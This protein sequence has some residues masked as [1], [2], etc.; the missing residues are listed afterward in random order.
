MS[1]GPLAFLSPWLLTGLLALPIIYWLLRTVPPRPKQVIFPPTRI[2]AGLENEEKQP[3]KTPWWLMLIR[4]LAAGLVILALADP[5]LNPNRAGGV[6]GKGPMVLVVDNTWAAAS[7]WSNR[8]TMLDR[9][10]AEAQSTSR[11]VVVAPTALTSRTPVAR[12]EAPNDAA[13]TAAAIQPQPYAPDRLAALGAVEK[14][15]AGRT[16]I[17]L[18]WLTDGLMHEADVQPVLDRMAKLA[19]AGVTVVEAGRGEEPLAVAADLGKAGRLEAIVTRPGGV[20]R[21]GFLH[22]YSQRGQR[23]GEA[24]FDF[25]AGATSTRTAFELPLEL[26]NQVFRIAVSANPSAGSVHLIDARS[27][28]QRIAII[29]GA[30]QEQAQPLLGPLYYIARAIR[31]FAEVVEPN[32][33]NIVENIDTALNQ[34]STVIIMADV[35]TLTDDVAERLGKWVEKGGV[36]VRFAGPRLEKG[37]DNLLPVPLRL[38]GRALGGALSWSTPQP[39]APLP[40]D[41]PFAGLPVTPDVTINR[42]V[43]AD[44]ARMGTD[45]KVWARLTDGTP[46]VTAAARENGQLVLFHITANAEWSNLPLSGLFVE[47]LRRLSTLGRLG[48]SGE[49][50]E[51]AADGAPAMAS[52]NE[53]NV[54]TPVQVLD[55]FGTLRTP[56]P[57]A[58]PIAASAF[59]KT[60]PG[61]DH[62][63]GYY[64]PKSAPRALNVANQKTI[65]KPL[66]ALPAGAERRAYQ[67]QVS[68]PLKP[69]LF[70]V[71]LALLFTDIVAVLLLQAGSLGAL[72]TRRAA[73]R[74]ATLAAVLAVPLLGLIAVMASH[75]AHAQSTANANS[76]ELDIARAVQA[77]SKVTFGYVLSG[78]QRIDETSRAGLSG[79]AKVLNARTA[80]EPGDPMPVEIER[81]EIAFFPVLYWPVPATATTLD[82]KTLAKVDAYMR[83][84]G[85]IIFDTRD[86]GQGGA[87][88]FGVEAGEGTPLQRLLGKLD[89]PRLE[90]IPEGHVLTKSFY[91]LTAFP[92]RWDGGQL[93]VEAATAGTGDGRQARRA[94]GVSTILVTSN[95]LA[96]AW[97]LDETNRPMYPT[98]PGGASQREMSF[99]VGINIAMYALT[100]NY[101][102]DQVHIPALLERLG[103]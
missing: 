95:D 59:T 48:G 4:L 74:A 98:V 52:G 45:A 87:N 27:R 1:L 31:P 43:L 100:G 12:V 66:P 47:M 88:T 57:T 51:S 65:L 6:A 69:T 78:D 29:G 13:S 33:A 85:M 83:Q 82:A 92:G 3:A 9:L 28:W 86:F 97:A 25:A 102:A 42:Q 64:G 71:A 24:R 54:L 62:P 36:L 68:T 58:R 5:V 39:L 63:P 32:S 7:G 37:G 30:S 73:A 84:G 93:W 40:D 46:L 70:A 55:G 72:F 35:G 101:K 81:D 103:Q 19:D 10:I 22:A 76:A 67:S 75:T 99:R 21:G 89:I 11:S 14:A 91:L 23:L 80:I 34:N 26:R 77:T 79:L 41:S 96:A 90:P 94:D 61:L 2:L 20:E 60:T 18:V 8:T 56:P 15:V 50:V 44:P 17:S 38:G 16:G 53:K 49:A